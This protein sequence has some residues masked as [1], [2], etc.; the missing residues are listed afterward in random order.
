MNIFHLNSE[1][2]RLDLHLTRTKNH[3]VRVAQTQTVR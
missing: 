3:V 2:Q 1:P